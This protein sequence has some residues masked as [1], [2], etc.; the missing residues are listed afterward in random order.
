MDWKLFATTFAT[1]FLAELGDKTQFAAVAA[2][3]RSQRLLEVLL[4]VVIAL[5]LA[6]ALGVLAGK[7]LAQF[8]DPRVMRWVSGGMFIAIGLWTL[9]AKGD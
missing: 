6:G 3:A 1:I 9:L 8:L 7:V 4:A 5:A 2:S